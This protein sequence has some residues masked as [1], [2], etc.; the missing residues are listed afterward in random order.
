MSS[1][2]FFPCFFV[3]RL[4]LIAPALLSRFLCKW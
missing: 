4:L 3:F 1:I 2:L